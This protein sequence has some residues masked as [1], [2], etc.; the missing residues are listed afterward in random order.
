MLP[1]INHS[2]ISHIIGIGTDIVSIE[3]ITK[4]LNSERRE[5]FLKRILTDYETQRYKNLQ[6]KRAISY[7]AKRFAAK[8]AVAKS[9]GVGIGAIAFNEIEICNNDLGQ[10]Y[11]RFLKQFPEVTELSFAV[12]ITDDG[13]F[14]AAT[15]IAFKS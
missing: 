15:V 4:L 12:S 6:D 3:R 8:E 7:L 14:A 5:K 2:P 1:N 9:L 13:S 11:I 10:P